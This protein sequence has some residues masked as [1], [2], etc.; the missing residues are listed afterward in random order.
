M[1][2]RT[3]MAVLALSI[4]GSA[5]T[6]AAFTTPP[7]G[8][9]APTYTVPMVWQCYSG[10]LERTS[11]VCATEPIHPTNVIPARTHYYLVQC[12]AQIAAMLGTGAW[13]HPALGDVPTN[14][15]NTTNI[16]ALANVGLDFWTNTPPAGMSTAT[17][18][19]NGL[20]RVI[21]NLMWTVTQGVPSDC[22]GSNS[23]GFSSGFYCSPS[24]LESNFIS[25]NVVDSFPI[26]QARRWTASPATNVTYGGSLVETVFQTCDGCDDQSYSGQST[27][28]FVQAAAY[29]STV[30]ICGTFTPYSSGYNMTEPVGS[31]C[32]DCGE[33]WVYSS[34]SFTTN[35]VITDPCDPNWACALPASTLCAHVAPITFTNCQTNIAFTAEEWYNSGSTNACFALFTDALFT[36]ASGAGLS[37]NGWK[38]VFDYTSGVVTGDVCR[39]NFAMYGAPWAGNTS[40]NPMGW[41]IYD[42]LQVRKYSFNY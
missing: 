13:I 37:S 31:D 9:G 32:P 16:C 15:L 41:A 2:T 39:T 6:F 24:A 21:T 10:L 22:N 14:R 12:K 34:W 3:K 40:T 36:D 1:K 20:R 17:N 11:V 7:F 25:I 35:T 23:Y 29:T 42:A 38:K 8:A 26:Y 5:A 27:S 28:V 18:G 33:I 4:A 19:W 30:Y